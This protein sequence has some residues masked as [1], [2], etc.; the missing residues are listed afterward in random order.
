MFSVVLA[1]LQVP[2]HRFPCI[3]NY[4]QTHILQCHLQALGMQTVSLE[5]SINYHLWTGLDP[6]NEATKDALGSDVI[7]LFVHS[8]WLHS[9]APGMK[10]SQLFHSQ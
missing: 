7:K 6:K 9:E 2:G 1:I 10:V 3:Y 4:E 8:L 5:W